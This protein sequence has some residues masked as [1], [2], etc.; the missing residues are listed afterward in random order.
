MRETD[1]AIENNIFHYRSTSHIFVLGISSLALF[2]LYSS[3]LCISPLHLDLKFLED[4]GWLEDG[5]TDDVC[6]FV[7]MDGWMGG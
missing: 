1:K 5:K 7:C 6:M 3:D 2:W 4:R